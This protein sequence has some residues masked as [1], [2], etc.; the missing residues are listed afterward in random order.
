VEELTIIKLGGSVITDKSKPLTAK[1]EAIRRL[2]R[3]IITS[4]YKGKLII[5]H[6]SGSFG[7]SVAKKHKTAEGHNGKRSLRGMV[8]TSSVAIEINRIVME[9]FIKLDMMVKSF[10]PSSFIISKN[11]KFSKG[12]IDPIKHTLKSDV[13][14]VVFGD[15]VMDLERGFCIFSAE[16]VVKYMVNSL[17]KKYNIASIIYCT[18]TEGVYDEKGVTIPEITSKNFKD[19]KKQI[20][21]SGSADVTGGM[22]H[23]VEESLKLAKK[24]GFEVKII[25]GNKKDNLKKVLGGKAV[26]A[27][28]IVS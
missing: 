4:K 11:K 9:E 7:H 5:T 21:K 27:T 18:D 1:R 24:Y 28:K 23:K 15:V 3:E 8:L 14:P 19:V 20:G 2:G 16:K 13:V 10:T 12:F 17:Q 6:G 22:I 26:K 25:N